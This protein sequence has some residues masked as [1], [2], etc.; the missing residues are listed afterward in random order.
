MW[1][2][3]YHGEEAYRTTTNNLN[4]MVRSGLSVRTAVRARFSQRRLTVY[5]V[6]YSRETEAR[7]RH[8]IIIYVMIRDRNAR[9][10]KISDIF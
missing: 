3:G 4:E 7:S 9:L 8:V 1:N 5:S 6:N 2:Y 10:K